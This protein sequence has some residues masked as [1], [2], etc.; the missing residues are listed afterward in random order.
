MKII[1]TAKDLAQI[2]TE[3]WEL[4]PERVQIALHKHFDA[5]NIYSSEIKIYPDLLPEHWLND[6]N[7]IKAYTNYLSFLLKQGRLITKEKQAAFIKLIH[8]KTL[9]NIELATESFLFSTA[10]EYTTP[11]VPNKEAIQL[12]G[13]AALP[14]EQ[15]IEAVLK[16][17]FKNQY[18][19]ENL[20]KLFVA[21][22]EW[23]KDKKNFV[24]SGKTLQ[25]FIKELS[26]LCDYHAP[27]AFSVL[28]YLGAT[29]TIELPLNYSIVLTFIQQKN[30]KV[31]GDN[32]K[33]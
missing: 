18:I 30:D 33:N 23:S 31:T 27:K 7:L 25:K 19:S 20:V 8:L 2:V 14:T 6:E 17:Y 13:I 10:K 11:F 24:F 4:L 26:V 21:F 12:I 5:V 32:T 22:L 9:D 29:E 3:N 28:K 1:E 15:E 16:T